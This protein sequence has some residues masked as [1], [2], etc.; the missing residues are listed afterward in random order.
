MVCCTMGDH[1][2]PM[3]DELLRLRGGSRARVRFDRPWGCP[4]ME[5]GGGVGRGGVG[6]VGLRRLE[7]GMCAFGLRSSCWPRRPAHGMSHP[8]EG[9]RHFCQC[10]LRTCSGLPH[11]C[12]GLP[13]ISTGMP[14]TCSGLSHTGSG[15]SHTG[16]GLSHTSTG[17]SHTCEGFPHPRAV[18]RGGAAMARRPRR[19]Y[20]LGLSWGHPDWWFGGPRALAPPSSPPPQSAGEDRRSGELPR[21]T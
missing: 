20:G 10:L 11:T 7:R 8:C 6:R 12:S 1:V 9:A 3:S 18:F 2:S 15:L 16:S 4:G 19:F 13:D 17:F 14:R 5:V 21:A